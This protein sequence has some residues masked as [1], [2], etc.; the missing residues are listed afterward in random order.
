LRAVIG[1]VWGGDGIVGGGGEGGEGGVNNAM[2][3]GVKSAAD[4]MLALLD[5]DDDGTVT[6]EEFAR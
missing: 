1:D 6:A 3:A 4:E 5:T 2:Y